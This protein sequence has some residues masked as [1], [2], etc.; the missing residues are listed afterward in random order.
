MNYLITT[1]LKKIWPK[2]YNNQIVFVS[3]SAIINYKNGDHIKYKHFKVNKP[4]W[5]DKNIFEKDFNYLL[6][7]YE[8]YLSILSKKLNKLHNKNFSLRFWRVLIG[9]WLST[10]I[11]IYFD[12]WNNVKSSIKNNKIDK[13]IYLQLS[14]EDFIPYDNKNFINYTQNDLWNQYLYQNIV[15]NFLKKKQIDIVETNK[16][17]VKKKLDES[18]LNKIEKKD[19]FQSFKNSFLKGLSFI[20]VRSYDYFFYDTYLGFKNE[21]YLSRKFNQ[22]PTIL[23]S[24]KSF[25]IKNIDVGLRNQIKNFCLGENFFEQNLIETISLFIPKIFIENFQDLEDFSKKENL[26]QKPKVIFTSGSLWYDTKISYHVAKSL[27]NKA[28]LIYGQHGGCIGMVKYHWPEQHEIKISNHYLTWGWNNK[29]NNKIKRFYFL[30]K[31]KN[32]ISQQKDLLIPLRVRKR[33]FHSLESSSG[34]ETYSDYINNLSIILKKL[35]KNVLEKTILR[36]PYKSLIIRDIDYFS[37]LE[38]RYKFYCEN[39]FYEACHRSK[40]VLHTSNSTPFLETISSNIP[41]ILIFDKIKNP[42]RHDCENIFN[43]LFEKNIVFYDFKKAAKFINSI[44]PNN[45]DSWWQ[46]KTTQKVINI[47][48]DRFARKDNFIVDKCYNFLKKFN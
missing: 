30:K 40:L 36:L 34:T 16:N 43:K 8:R 22:L 1:P 25:K 13:F 15:I 11:H 20:D 31:S 32:I 12:R 7:I 4:R 45:I 18:I 41:S 19:F 29:S 14:M 37:T 10:F 38:K 2:K 5:N 24:Q 33:Y 27:E 44:W 48:N 21:F 46:K 17:F 35:N 39:S 3:E 26:P 23:N 42:I 6:I 9:P 28:K 47:F